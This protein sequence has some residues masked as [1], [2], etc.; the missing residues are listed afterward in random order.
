[1]SDLHTGENLTSLLHLCTYCGKPPV[2][3]EQL[4][5]CSGCFA[6]PVYCGAPCQAADWIT[7]R[8]AYHGISR[9]SDFYKS[10]MEPSAQ[11]LGYESAYALSR[12]MSE[13]LE[14]HKWTL[15]A[16]I[17]AYTLLHFGVWQ[18]AASFPAD[19]VLLLELVS[20]GP[21]RNPAEG[22][23]LVSAHWRTV[24]E[25][26]RE[27]D[28]PS[29]LHDPEVSKAFV[30]AKKA[31]HS[32]FAA[33]ARYVGVLPVCFTIGGFPLVF[34]RMVPQYTPS[35]PMAPLTEIPWVK[36]TM[37][38]MTVF[39]LWCINHQVVLRP[40]RTVDA[41]R[42]TPAV[43]GRLVRVRGSWR[44]RPFFTQWTDLSEDP[45]PELWEFLQ[46][47]MAAGDQPP[48]FYM[49]ILDMFW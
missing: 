36:K 44:W 34:W 1:M 28:I 31:T 42:P 40:P 48:T 26:L 11:M 7:H 49:N 27:A 3:G 19:K 24:G 20:L 6:G 21:D 8:T 10:V 35:N 32:H 16:L 18:F 30:R 9:D 23:R 29:D 17:K 5:R 33:R 14:A 37:N 4:K 39:C 25:W 47:R 38:D 15:A 13:Y 2:S 41:T 22:F 12:G 46:G 43:P 45:C